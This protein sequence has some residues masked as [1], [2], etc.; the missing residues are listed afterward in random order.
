MAQETEVVVFEVDVSSYEKSL[1][2]LT[3]SI[4]G[5]KDTQAELQKQTKDGAKGAAESLEKVN[6]QLKLQQQ[7]YRTTQNILVLIVV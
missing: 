5:L 2:D 7:E 4:N 3:K 6:A 1:A